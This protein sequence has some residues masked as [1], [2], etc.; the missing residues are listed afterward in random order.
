MD[1]IR[2]EVEV[3]GADIDRAVNEGLAKLGLERSE[4]IVEVVDE[5]SRGLLGLGS[6][7]AIVIVKEITPTGDP[8]PEPEPTPVPEPPKPKPAVQKAPKKPQQQQPKPKAQEKK[9]P[10]AQKPKPV[11]K[12]QNQKAQNTA[13]SKPKPAPEPVEED[14]EYLEKEQALAIEI[15]KGLIEKMHVEAEVSATVSEPDDLTG[16]R[17]NVINVNGNDLGVLIGPR[18]DTL[19]SLQYVSRLMVGHR[20]RS[21]ANFAIDVEGYRQRR[22]TALRRLAERM[23]DKVIKQGRAKTLEPMPPNERRIIHMTLR[24]HEGVNTHSVGEGDRR[25]V[26]I[27]LK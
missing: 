7:D 27:V 24:D 2:R 16:K 4:V 3:R 26:R 17:M 21:R 23:A 18:G 10:Q 8:E 15:I 11:P 12:P 13:V 22:E 14:P 1:K 9:K 19:S 6:R 25:K 20:L 5:G